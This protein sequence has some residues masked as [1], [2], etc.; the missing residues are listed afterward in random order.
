MH[1]H[2][3]MSSDAHAHAKEH[4]END[5]GLRVMGRF[6]R[7]HKIQ[8]VY[9]YSFSLLQPK[10]V[11]RTAGSRDLFSRL[12]PRVL[13]HDNFASIEARNE[14]LVAVH[15][16]CIGPTFQIDVNALYDVA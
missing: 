6:A 15:T 12:G 7:Y 1:M 3:H 5:G 11:K 2:M 10:A 8:G 16:N 4:L 9:R 13:E 14:D